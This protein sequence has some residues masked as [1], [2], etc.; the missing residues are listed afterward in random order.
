MVVANPSFEVI[1]KKGND[2][3]KVF[4]GENWRLHM[5]FGNLCRSAETHLPDNKSV[6][7]QKIML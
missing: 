6:L 5:V 7:L 1:F 3:T 4:K 2:V